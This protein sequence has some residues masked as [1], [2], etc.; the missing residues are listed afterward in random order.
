MRK[1][2]LRAAREAFAEI[3]GWVDS[4]DDDLCERDA[5]GNRKDSDE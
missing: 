2:N 4:I 3:K 5:D 1:D